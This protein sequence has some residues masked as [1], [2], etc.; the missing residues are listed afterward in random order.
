MSLLYNLKSIE[1][2]CKISIYCKSLPF[3]RLWPPMEVP[4]NNQAT[5]IFF[6]WPITKCSNIF[7]FSAQQEKTQQHLIRAKSIYKITIVILR[8][9]F[10]NNIFRLHS[11]SQLTT[12]YYIHKI[13]LGRYAKIFGDLTTWWFKVY[14]DV[15][16]MNNNLI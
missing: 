10:L 6:G 3:S 11:V 2:K 16:N 8:K 12:Y 14:D 7:R 1:T 9:L 13:L 5:H 4:I 15:S